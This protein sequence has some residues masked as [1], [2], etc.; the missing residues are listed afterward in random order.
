[1][2][3]LGSLALLLLAAAPALCQVRQA[4]TPPQAPAATGC[5]CDPDCACDPCRC[6]DLALVQLQEQAKKSETPLPQGPLSYEIGYKLALRQRRPFV[7]FVGTPSMAIKGCVIAEVDSL[8]ATTAPAVVVGVPKGD[9][10]DGQ[11]LQGEQTATAIKTALN[12]LLFP[13]S[14]DTPPIARTDATAF[15]G[16]AS[17]TCGAG[18]CATCGNGR[19]LP[20]RR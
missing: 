18:C 13:A 19:G 14:R 8:P 15:G 1:M 9:Y 3:C 2:K 4:P 5:P 20:R 16:C 10:I 12:K 17:P 11:W 7:V 6:C